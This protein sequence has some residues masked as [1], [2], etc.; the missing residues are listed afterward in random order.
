MPYELSKVSLKDIDLERALLSIIGFKG[1]ASRTFKLKSQ[2][3]ALLKWYIKQY[4][5]DRAL[6]SGSEAIGKAWRR[7]RA[8]S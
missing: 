8:F 2:T 3:M 6:F 7:A 1:H 5:N 4:S